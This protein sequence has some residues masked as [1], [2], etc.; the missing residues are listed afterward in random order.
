MYF[1]VDAFIGQQPH[2]VLKNRASGVAC[3]VKPFF[4]KTIHG[5]FVHFLVDF[6][7]GDEQ[8]LEG[9]KLP[10]EPVH[11]GEGETEKP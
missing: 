7:L 3:A 1:F 2:F 4:E 9:L 11:Q 5:G 8:A 10:E 6:P